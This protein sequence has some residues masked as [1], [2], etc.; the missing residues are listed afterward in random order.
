[1]SE[2][3]A[4]DAR[5]PS[6]E[7]KAAHF[8]AT[9]SFMDETRDNA[10]G[11]RR[12]GLVFG[13]AGMAIGVLGMAVGVLGW[14]RPQTPAQY[15]EV[16]RSTGWVGDTTGPRDAPRLFNEQVIVAAL[17]SYVEDREAF[18][19]E[20]DDLAFHRVTLCSS[21]DEQARYADA[22]DAR[23]HP[24]TAPFGYYG[25]GGFARVENFHMTRRG[26]DKK[27][28][29]YDYAVDFTKSVWRPG[30]TGAQ[31]PWHANVQFQFHPE[32]QM[33]AQDRQLNHTG[34]E[35]IGYNSFT[36]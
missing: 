19:P 4:W 21:L 27:T 17:R 11:L 36:D 29:T 33:S 5:A 23:K 13:V 3:A 14:A 31:K 26:F 28:G 8:A 22:H 10:R 6:A 16:D 30:E 35:V 20:T 9:R 7:Q 2:A 1:M 12:M 18:V 15:I 34:L 24:D 32:M 25:K